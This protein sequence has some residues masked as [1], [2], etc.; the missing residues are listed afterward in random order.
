MMRIGLTAVFVFIMLLAEGSAQIAPTANNVPA[1]SSNEPVSIEADQLEVFD[2]E[3][4]AIYT[5]SVVVTQGETVMKAQV[6][7]IFYE[8]G[9]GTS[10]DE[11]P[12]PKLLGGDDAGGAVLKRVDARG[13]VTIISK[14]Q[15]ATGDSGVYE[16][17]TDI[18]TLMGN[19]TLT[20][21]ANVTKGEKL[22]Y[23]VGTGVAF[24]EAGK[25][26]RVSSSFVSGGS[27]PAG[28]VGNKPKKPIQAQ[29]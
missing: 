9:T 15:I 22:V 25:S 6:M 27:K 16:R 12:S 21:G 17:M 3:Q 13:G 7:T 8:S 28:G 29:P 19:V 24:V 26:G 11:S 1:A 20:Q 23:N 2:K 14:D 4:R 5:G 18:M 10:A